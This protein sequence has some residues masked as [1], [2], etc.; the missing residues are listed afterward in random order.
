MGRSSGGAGAW[1][2]Q[3]GGSTV[4]GAPRLAGPRHESWYVRL[5]LPA[6][7]WT[8]RPA[9]SRRGGYPSRMFDDTGAITPAGQ[10]ICT[11]PTGSLTL[12]R[13]GWAGRR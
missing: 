8:G 4:R 1:T 3:S 5:E 11:P 10:V 7:G 6:G 2:R 9:G 13:V 12:Y